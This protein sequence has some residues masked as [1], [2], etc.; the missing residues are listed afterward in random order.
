MASTAQ[1]TVG[2][3]VE[4]RTDGLEAFIR[5]VDEKSQR[6]VIVVINDEDLSG[7]ETMRRL[8]QLDKTGRKIKD[9]KAAIAAARA[10]EA[11]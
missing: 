8:G 10:G 9:V 11:V 1:L 2:T 3:R 5:R 6:A 4:T 7:W